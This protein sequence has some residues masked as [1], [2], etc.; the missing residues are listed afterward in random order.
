MLAP[1][2]Y[3]DLAGYKRRSKVIPQDVNR[4]DSLY[5]G[6]LDHRIARGSSFINGRLKKRYLVPLGQEAPV[7]IP[8]GTAPPQIVLS[9]RPTLG[10][11]EIAIQITTPGASGTAVFQWSKDGGL[12]WTTGVGTVSAGTVVLSGTGLVAAFPP[13]TLSFSADDA[14]SASTPVPEIA[15]G[16]LAAMLDVDVW[17]RRGAN[18]QDPSIAMGIAE[19]DAALSE[20]KEAADAK[21]GLFDLPTNDA[22]GDS[23]VTQGGP[24]FYS[25]SSPYVWMSQQRR[26]ARG[27]DCAG[28]GTSGSVDTP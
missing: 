4:C 3:F 24:L 21:D 7:L 10:S 25:E 12:T 11:L 15:L 14:Y 23:A 17:E 26:T 8:T 22:A 1:I 27:E 18:P 16:W 20:I 28:V 13:S 9:G 5:P 19:R 2:P 6:Y